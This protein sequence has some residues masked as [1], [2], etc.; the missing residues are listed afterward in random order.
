[1]ISI[2][3]QKGKI[4]IAIATTIP[5]GFRSNDS[6]IFPSKSKVTARVVPQ[7]GQA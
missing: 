4:V 1:M 2:N 5:N 3:T 6:V 7:D